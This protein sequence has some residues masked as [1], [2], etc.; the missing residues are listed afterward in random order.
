MN[1]QDH[2]DRIKQEYEK[3]YQQCVVCWQ[4]VYGDY[5]AE[6]EAECM[7]SQNYRIALK[8]HDNK[9][10][11]LWYEIALLQACATFR[12]EDKTCDNLYRFCAKIILAIEQIKQSEKAITLEVK[13]E[14]TQRVQ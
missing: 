1:L 4:N 11:D 13:D 7:L 10:E 14:D 2:I 12:H 8:Y 9:E 6:V 5:K 3:Q